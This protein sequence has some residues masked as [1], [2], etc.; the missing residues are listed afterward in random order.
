MTDELSGVGVNV[1][2]VRAMTEKAGASWCVAVFAVPEGTQ[3]VTWGRTPEDKCEASEVAEEISAALGCG[4][5]TRVYE[6]FK[7]DA[8]KNKARVEEL[9]D[10]L[11]KT[12]DSLD[13]MLAFKDVDFDSL[14]R[15]RDEM[16]EALEGE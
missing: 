8:A 11:Q 1:I 3:F 10:V 2:D 6:S 15:R 4:E 16:R 13:G 9:E 5:K 7:L 12:L 14:R